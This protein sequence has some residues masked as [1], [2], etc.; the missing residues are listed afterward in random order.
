[1]KKSFQKGMFASFILTVFSFK[2]FFS[3]H[4]SLSQRPSVQ[5]PLSLPWE[6]QFFST[7]REVFSSWSSSVLCTPQWSSQR[8]TLRGPPG[9]E[10]NNCTMKWDFW[11][12]WVF[13]SSSDFSLELYSNSF[14]NGYF[15]TR[16]PGWWYK[17]P[18]QYHVCPQTGQSTI[19]Q[20]KKTL[21]SMR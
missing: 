4:T 10:H 19:I 7:Q 9:L 21:E 5:Y 11:K 20:G 17:S 2:F 3:Q 1:M 14:Q 8:S 16:S 6:T 13:S 15:I 12:F 18:K